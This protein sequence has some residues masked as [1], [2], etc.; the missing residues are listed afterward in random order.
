MTLV[1]G[2]PSGPFPVGSWPPMI[3][4]LQPAHFPK[5]FNPTFCCLQ[6]RY[7]S[8]SQPSYFLQTSRNHLSRKLTPSFGARVL[9]PVSPK[10]LQVN[11]FT[12][13]QSHLALLIKDPKYPVPNAPLF[14]ASTSWQILAAASECRSD[15]AHCYVSYAVTCHWLSA[16]L[17]GG[18]IGFW[19]VLCCL[20]QKHCNGL[21][22]VLAFNKDCGWPLQTPLFRGVSGAESLRTSAQLSPL[23]VSGSQVFRQVICP[24][25]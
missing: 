24:W 9:N 11:I 8:A 10:C 14:P 7:F 5:L 13:I 25:L 15:L 12:P 22:G 6:F 19:G 1:N 23:R 17:R 4:A 16:P 3:Y 20:A 2:V 18:E 21:G